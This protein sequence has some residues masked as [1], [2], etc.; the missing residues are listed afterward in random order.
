MRFTYPYRLFLLGFALLGYVIIYGAYILYDINIASPLPILFIPIYIL[1]SI[2]VIRFYYVYY[3][4]YKA[5]YVDVF[6]EH[7]EI[8]INNHCIHLA[9]SDIE[10]IFLARHKQHLKIHRV[11]HIFGYDG[12]YFYITNEINRFNKLVTFI[13]YYYPE[14]TKVCTRLV[15]GVQAINK[16]VLRS[17][18]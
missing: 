1:I 5:R 12:T 7:I 4:Y 16:D 11:I 2:Q 6:M 3:K 17:F 14:K 9:E 15:K 10:V 18:L 13:R 8:C